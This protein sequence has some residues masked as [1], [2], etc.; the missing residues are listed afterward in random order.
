MYHAETWFEGNFAKILFTKSNLSSQKI[1]VLLSNLGN[2]TLQ[3][4][5]FTLYLSELKEKVEGIIIDGTPLPNKIN[6]GFNA[7]GHNCGSI[8]E[9]MRFLCVI[10]QKTSAPLFFRYLPGNIIDVSTLKATML[11]LKEYGIK[12]NFLLMDAG[13]FSKENVI[14]L[15]NEKINFLTRLPSSNKIYQNLVNENIS[16]LENFKNGVSLGTRGLFIK[17]V[18]LNL[19]EKKASPKS[20]LELKEVLKSNGQEVVETENKYGAFAYI[21]SDPERKGREISKL[22]SQ[23]KDNTP[24]KNESLLKLSGVFI[25]IS[26][27]EI[28]E[29]DV[30]PYYYLR[31]QVE[32]VFG[33]FKDDLNVL[34]LRTHNDET[35]KGYLFLT[36]INLIIFLECRKMLK[37]KFT[38]EQALMVMRNLK[39]KIFNNHLII[40]ELTKKQKEITKLF[41]IEVPKN[42]KIADC[43]A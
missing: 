20:Y 2:E 25:L 28:R 6:V 22:L 30:V 14:D 10:D 35:V 7:W 11:E 31:Q 23:S 21:I 43:C 33:F 36:F 4:K 16:D 40:H 26:S 29:S 32:Q 3:R 1:S 18:P 41:D 5:F 39:C 42:L 13:Y 17:K 24:E 9:Q 38:V 27:F 37:N 8:D 12:N 19:Y 34:P 15:Y